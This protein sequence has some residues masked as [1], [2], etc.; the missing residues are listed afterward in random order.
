MLAHAGA[1]QGSQN[2]L[3]KIVSPPAPVDFL[4]SLEGIRIM[5]VFAHLLATSRV[6]HQLD[7]TASNS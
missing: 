4:H 2:P 7:S 5:R 1:A 6:H 3:R